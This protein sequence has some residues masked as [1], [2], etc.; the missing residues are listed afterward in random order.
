V[1]RG[2]KSLRS[3]AARPKGGVR[4]TIHLRLNS[5]TPIKRHAMNTSDTNDPTSPTIQEPPLD[6]TSPI[7][8]LPS[9]P[10]T[11]PAPDLPAA[12]SPAARAEVVAPDARP[13]CA[14]LGA[15]F[16]GVLG[17]IDLLSA[18]QEQLLQVC[19]GK[20]R[21]IWHD[22]VEAG[23]ALGEIRDG[24]LYRND[25]RSFE[26]YCQQRWEFKRG[27]GDYLIAAARM[28]RR[29]ADTP[30]IP[31][32]ERESQLRPLFAVSLADAEL[33]WQ[34][35][36]QVSGGR[37]ITA[38]LVKRAVK[39]LQLPLVKAKSIPLPSRQSKREI[40][41]MVAETMQALLGLITQRA[42]HSALLQN[43]EILDSQLRLLFKPEQRKKR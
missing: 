15:S 18:E 43:Y 32:P 19:E 20:V 37:P 36:S 30:G 10:P 28:R 1:V 41:R 29:I 31:Q 8:P 2:W 5:A 12:V 24:R 3:K 38:R 33:A 9:G 40:R 23:L 17:Q 7:S 6:P 39:E 26:Q 14:E 25:F 34:Y 11:L 13:L 27:K 4:R 35:A 16:S 22:Y 42:D 21:T